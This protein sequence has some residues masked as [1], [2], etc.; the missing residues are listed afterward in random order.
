MY[1]CKELH[2][3]ITPFGTTIFDLLE[4]GGQKVGLKNSPFSWLPGWTICQRPAGDHFCVTAP[5]SE[6][7]EF[8]QVDLKKAKMERQKS[9]G[10]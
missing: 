2:V 8:C 9:I 3:S 6:A 5:T 4:L 1:F 7:L 10:I